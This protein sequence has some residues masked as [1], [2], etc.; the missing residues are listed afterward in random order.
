MRFGHLFF[1]AATA[2]YNLIGVGLEARAFVV[3]SAFRC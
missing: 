1:T 3:V 2:G